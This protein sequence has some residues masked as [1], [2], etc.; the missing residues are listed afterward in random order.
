MKYIRT[1]HN[2]FEVINETDIVYR[3]IGASREKNNVYSKSK[4]NTN[5]IKSSD[6]IEDLLDGFVVENTNDGNW[7]FMDVSE[8]KN[9][10][11]YFVNYS[12]TGF[13]KTNKGFIYVAKVNEQGKLELC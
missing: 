1:E 8:F 4:C 12:Y 5:V 3:V 7:F 13:I 9:E 6:H 2:I 11:E 10:K